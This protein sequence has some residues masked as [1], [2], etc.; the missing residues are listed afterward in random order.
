MSFIIRKYY[1]K[2][3][4][5]VSSIPNIRCYGG[6]PEIQGLGALKI[7]TKLL[8]DKRHLMPRRE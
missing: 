2:W 4:K 6:H 8:N 1:T 5:L 7:L 3:R